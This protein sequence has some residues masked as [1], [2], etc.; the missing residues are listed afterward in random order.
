MTTILDYIMNI[1]NQYLREESAFMQKILI[2]NE[3]ERE[4]KDEFMREWKILE[5]SERENINT[6]QL[7]ELK[8]KYYKKKLKASM[9]K[10]K[11]N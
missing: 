5:F 6:L 9:S 3:K 7:E 8:R 4:Y 11:K 1:I 10:N 2:E